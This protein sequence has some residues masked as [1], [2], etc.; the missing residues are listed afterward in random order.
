MC[1][2]L[3]TGP[4]ILV[5]ASSLAGAQP[6]ASTL[7]HS[8]Q[9]KLDYLASNAARQHPDPKPTEL[10]QE[11]INAYFASGAVKLPAGVQSLRTALH[12]DRILGTAT[13][14]FDKVRA[15]RNQNNP[16]LSMFS[17][18]HQVLVDANAEGAEAHGT[19][20]VNSVAVDGIPIPRIALQLF[21]D[22]YIKPKYP[23]IGL[24]TRFALPERIYDAKISEGMVTLTQR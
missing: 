6:Q 21:V 1:S 19:I 18:V 10:S 8:A 9:T 13:V 2:R 15:G 23:N 5:L 22:K 14:D 24:E 20:N 7:S 11:E 4:V 17:G 16:L 3:I 12:S